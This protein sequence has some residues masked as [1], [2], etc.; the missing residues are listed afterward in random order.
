MSQCERILITPEIER[1]LELAK[2]VVTLSC[3]GVITGPPGTGKT[4]AL[5][6]IQNKYP[7]LELPGKC[8]FVRCCK[9][10][11]TATG[12]KQILVSLGMKEAMNV[13]GMSLDLAIRMACRLMP[14]EDY[15]LL[16]LDEA[17]QLDEAS[18]AGTISML[19][20]L[21]L[22]RH[23]MG[24]ILT[25][26]AD[27]DKWL[28]QNTS[29][30]SR[31]VQWEV[32]APQPILRCL[33]VMQEWLPAFARLSERVASGDKDSQKLIRLIHKGCGGNL[34]KLKFFCQLYFLHFKDM[35]VNM[36]SINAVFAKMLHEDI[37]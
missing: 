4:E 22:K 27:I 26:V 12:V 16:L 25:G 18:L 31:T 8:A 23:P 32:F 2:H 19:D 29:S 15:R 9:A 34:R 21:K 17:E 10:E 28:G 3:I 20:T 14:A 30:T 33:S 6:T 13:R 7:T 1:A 35:E 11:G 36:E 37:Q 24:V 5:L